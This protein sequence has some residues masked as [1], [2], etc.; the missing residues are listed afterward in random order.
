MLQLKYCILTVSYRKESA[1]NIR[2]I[3]ALYRWMKRRI[4]R[5]YNLIF[6]RLL[7]LLGIFLWWR[8]MT[9]VFTAF[10]VLLLPVSVHFTEIRMIVNYIIFPKT[11]VPF[12]IL[13]GLRSS[14]YLKTRTGS[15]KIYTV[16]RN[17]EECRRLKNVG[18]VFYRLNSW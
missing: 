12:R 10:A 18:I 4:L 5:R 3:S 13:C 1:N 6:C 15:I 9:R 2:S 17:A 8:M 11:I 16:K 7:R 14:L